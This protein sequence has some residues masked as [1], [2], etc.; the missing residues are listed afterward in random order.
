VW[1]LV[2]AK[3]RAASCAWLVEL[4]LQAVQVAVPLWAVVVHQWEPAA[5][6]RFALR[7]RRRHQ[8][9][10]FRLFREDL[11]AEALEMHLLQVGM[12]VV[13]VQAPCWLRQVQALQVAVAG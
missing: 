3:L 11:Q 9:E 13:A 10:M 1:L 5:R 4:A 12:P 2:L 6:C 7:I 8:V